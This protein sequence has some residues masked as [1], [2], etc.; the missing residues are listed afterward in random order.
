M[1]DLAICVRLPLLKGLTAG[2]VVTIQMK[3]F[4]GSKC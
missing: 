2:V 4:S 1:L 3:M